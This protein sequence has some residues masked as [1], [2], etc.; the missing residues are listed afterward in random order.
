MEI[1]LLAHSGASAD[2]RVLIN[3]CIFKLPQNLSLEVYL[4]KCLVMVL[5]SCYSY[6]GPVTF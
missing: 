4:L 2:N 6:I 5:P 1:T 3:V